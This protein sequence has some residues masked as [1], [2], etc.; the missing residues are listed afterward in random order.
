MCKV[1]GLTVSN[2]YTN[3]VFF[4]LEITQTKWLSEFPE[5]E[6]VLDR[7]KKRDPCFIPPEN[8]HQDFLY[9]HLLCSKKQTL[10][11]TDN[12]GPRIDYERAERDTF[13]KKCN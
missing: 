5:I 11:E 10:R 4:A 7:W 8:I 6:L 3:N 2:F 1:R 12:F 13:G 9:Y